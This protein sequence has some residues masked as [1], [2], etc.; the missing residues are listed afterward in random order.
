MK[1]R[2]FLLCA[3][4]LFSC[5]TIKRIPVS[6]KDENAIKIANEFL[7]KD[8]LEFYNKYC[9]NQI[10]TVETRYIENGEY[11]GL[12][13][14]IVT[15]KYP[16]NAKNENSMFINYAVKVYINSVTG[17]VIT[18]LLGPDSIGKIYDKVLFQNFSNNILKL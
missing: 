7:K 18:K 3:V 4:L 16:E 14:Q 6:Q 1:Y 10:P 17:Q 15:Y 13:I 5:E 9:S 11:Q 8:S 2:I 12:G